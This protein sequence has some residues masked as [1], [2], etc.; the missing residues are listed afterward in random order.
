[1][2]M[3]NSSIVEEIVRRGSIR[4]GD[5]A[6]LASAYAVADMLSEHDADALFGIHSA[7]PIQDPTWSPLFVSAICDYVVHQSLP[8][9]YAV[10][11]N[12]RWLT[13][14]IGRYGRVET[15]TEL[16]LLI[17]VLET[18]RWAPPSLAAFA[19]D[20]IKHAIETATGPLRTN[21]E[22]TPGSLTSED[23]N[24]AVRIIRALGAETSL[25]VTRAEANSLIDINRSL[26][27]D[28]ST[29]AWSVLFVR[30]IGTAVLAATGHAAPP[31]RDLTDP[32]GA[33]LS[34]AEIAA[35]LGQNTQPAYGPRGILPRHPASL[36]IWS[37]MAVQ[38]AEERAIARLERQRHEIITNEVI[39]EPTDVWLMA[40]LSEKSSLDGN[41]A[42][43]LA[44]ISREASRLPP[45]LAD[46]VARTAI[47]A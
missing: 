1:M 14:R 6:S 45:A 12:A 11:E 26:A 23:V 41:E 34:G 10:A 17:H 27:P 43:L 16:S 35:A 42:A 5:V 37:T 44:F 3:L 32:T 24:L 18:A 36:N 33:S 46:F 19:L 9:G 20:Q 29:P 40:R 4:D 39:E 31:R 30:A 13:E 15:S 2:S 38:T 25:P 47:A 8:S 7:C 21:R 22:L 28:K